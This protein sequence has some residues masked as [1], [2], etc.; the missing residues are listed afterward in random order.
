MNTG[1]FQV[2]HFLHL[3]QNGSKTAS[4]KYRVKPTVDYRFGNSPDTMEASMKTE[5]RRLR[6][7]DRGCA[8]GL[9]NG[10]GTGK[11]RRHRISCLCPRMSALPRSGSPGGNCAVALVPTVCPDADIGVTSFLGH[12]E[13][14]AE[15]GVR[16][17]RHRD[18]GRGAGGLGA[19][20]RLK[21]L[22]NTCE[23]LDTRAENFF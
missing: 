21:S 12:F 10:L 13:P 7:A 15:R 19:E 3:L 17:R 22:K 11:A 14:N 8:G 5:D 1:L 23:H 16:A 9:H 2:P 18:T 20:I 4:K 6:M